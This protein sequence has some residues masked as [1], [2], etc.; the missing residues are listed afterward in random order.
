[1]ASTA[2]TSKQWSGPGM[3]QSFLKLKKDSKLSQ[4]T[5]EKWWEEEYL[6]KVLDTGIISAAWTLK[7]A[8]PN[9]EKQ[10]MVMYRV[11]D[12]APVQSETLKNIPRTSNLFPTDG[13]V[14]DF[15]DFESRIFSFVQLHETEKQP[16]GTFFVNFEPF[17]DIR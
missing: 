6:P 16:E 2:E 9:N 4:E 13:P 10:Q 1:M 15:I 7:A 14:D 12:L 17:M 8:D 3:M 11:P 5:L